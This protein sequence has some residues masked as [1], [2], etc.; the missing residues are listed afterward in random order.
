M[1]NSISLA[2]LSGAVLTYEDKK[3]NVHKVKFEE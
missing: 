2:Q 1:S 3:G